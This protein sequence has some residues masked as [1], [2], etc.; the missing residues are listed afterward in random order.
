MCAV[1]LDEP[2]WWYGAGAGG[3]AERLLAPL[4]DLYA[5]AVER[6]FS[7]AEPYR[8]A[9]PVICVGNFTAGGTGKTPL[10]RLLIRLFAE[11]GRKTAVLSR[12]YG[13]AQA[14]PVWVER[15]RHT[16]RDVGDEPLLV[17]LDAPVMVARDRKAG[18]QAIEAHGEADAV[19]MDDGLQNPHVAKALS[20]A[21]V[22]GRRGFGNGRVIPAGPL[23]ARL[24]FQLGLVDCIVVMGGVGPEGEAAVL[25][26]L[27]RRFHGPVL[28][29][30]VAA[31]GD[32]SWAKDGALLA[33]AGIGNPERFFRMLEGL[34]ARSVMR[35]AFADH[36]VFTEGDA[37]RLLADSDA[38]DAQLITTEKDLARLAGAKG[39]CRDLAG[40]SR[41]LPIAVAFEERDLVRLGALVDGVLKARGS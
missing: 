29:G 14:G 12:G 41:A 2:A 40:R 16:A 17:A 25:E 7:K 22:D 36:H 23:R 34:G 28:S 9:L 1:R 26:D 21:V 8:S 31:T 20:I 11:R 32:T 18:L 15:D 6:R 39:A 13:G 35:R 38:A 3:T 5:G 37:R 27:K 24:A 4:G 30:A 33:Y 19:I 10:A